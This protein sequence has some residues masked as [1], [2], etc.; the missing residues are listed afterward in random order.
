MYIHMYTMAK[1]IMVSN[2][3]YE[4]LTKIKENSPSMSYS[5]V[6][7]SSLESKRKPFGELKEVIKK[8]KLRNDD[9][10]IEKELKERWH[11]WTK[12]YA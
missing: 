8:M 1:T 2:E 5:D 4:K 12:K 11:R 9:K 10:K 6:I 3:V 7:I